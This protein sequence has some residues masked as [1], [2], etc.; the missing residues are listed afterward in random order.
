[1]PLLMHAFQSVDAL[2]AA[3]SFGGSFG[4]DV[5]L[6]W[7]H[8]ILAENNGISA[9]HKSGGRIDVEEAGS[10]LDLGGI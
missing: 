10:R 6:L 2:A 9:G 3:S 1:M 8:G 5:N 4:R 7:K